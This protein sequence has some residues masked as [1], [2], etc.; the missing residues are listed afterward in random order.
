MKQ[1]TNLR[2]LTATVLYDVLEQG[3]S[4]S[5]LLPTLQITLS[6]KDSA[7]LSELC[8]GILRTLPQHE[9]MIQKLMKKVLKNKNRVLHYLIITGIYQLTHTR[10]P[11]HA[12]L[13]ETVAGATALNR[14]EFTKLING[15]LREY[16]RQQSSLLTAFAKNGNTTLHPAWL[17]NRLQQTYHDEW[18]SIITANNQKPPMWLRINRNIQPTTYLTLLSEEGI[19]AEC[20]SALPSAIRLLKPVPVSKLPGFDE[21]WVTVQDLSAQ[22]AAYYLEPKN[23]ELILDLCAAPGGKTT[24]ILELAPNA[25][26]IAVDNDPNRAQRINDNLNR[27]NLNAI[28]KVG[29]GRYPESWADNDL[30]DRILLDAPCSATGVIRRH[31]DI[32]WLRRD[33][34]IDALAKLQYQILCAIWPYLKPGGRLVYTTCSVLPEENQRQIA[35]FLNQTLDASLNQAIIQCLPNQGGGDGFFYAVVQKAKV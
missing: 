15:V 28:V 16:Q 9:F 2:A 13:S 14:K 22:Y 20:D 25:N 5:K 27:L 23:G 24:H 3:K 12:A 11:H 19:D 30:F 6:A 34:D 7:L 18:Q 31:P 35:Q 33:S 29:D 8:F 26:V 17:V 1:H 4:L 21:G 10:I 32:K